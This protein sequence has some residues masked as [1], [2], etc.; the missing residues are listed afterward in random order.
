MDSAEL[1]KR[2]RAARGYA[3]MNRPALASAIGMSES[4][5]AGGLIRA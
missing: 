1:G 5:C 3:D 4:Y 2:V